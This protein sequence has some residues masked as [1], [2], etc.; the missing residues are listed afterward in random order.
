MGDNAINFIPIIGLLTRHAWCRRP[1][2]IP[3]RHF[4]FASHTA[5]CHDV[6]IYFEWRVLKI[7]LS[8]FKCDD[9]ARKLKFVLRY[10][11]TNWTNFALRAEPLTV[12]GVFFLGEQVCLGFPWHLSGARWAASSLCAHKILH[13]WTYLKLNSDEDKAE[14]SL[15]N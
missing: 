13:I 2:P 11:K 14:N 6:E 3:S 1:P 9:M 12:M 8:G 7:L 4:G 5:L 15:P 10:H